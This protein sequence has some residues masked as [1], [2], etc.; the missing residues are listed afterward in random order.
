MARSGIGAEVEG[1]HAVMA[2]L[3][4]GRMERLYLEP[5][6]QLEGLVEEARGA[7]VAVEFVD[8]ARPLATTEAPQ[9]VVG[10]GRPIPTVSL[11][12]AAGLADPS[13]VVIL[14]HLE[15][16]HNVGA[17]ARSLLAAGL[18]AMV[19]PTRRAAPVGPTAFKA[20]AGALEEV[21]V[22]LVSST[23]D[24]VRRLGEL[25][26]WTVGL[27]SSGDR[28]LFGLDLLAEPVALVIGSEGGGLARL[29]EE[30]VDVR[31][32]IPLVGPVE[33]LNASVAVALGAYELARVRGWTG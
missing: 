33:S 2:A 12:E 29:V 3:R 5:R 6:P 11:E 31:A 23:A 13:A 9:G 27:T 15:D 8:D 10:R 22:A 4:A 28:S 14:D 18:R 19:V 32:R 7:G 16:P 24:A 1:L 26:L 30:R 20:A 25:G 21:R 17:A